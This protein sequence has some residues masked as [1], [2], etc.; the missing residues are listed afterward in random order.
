MTSS[1]TRIVVVCI[2]CYFTLMQVLGNKKIP[3]NTR[4]RLYQANVVSQHS[5]G[6]RVCKEA[7]IIASCVT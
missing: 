1:R 3:M 7:L 4:R 5:R 2:I 6:A